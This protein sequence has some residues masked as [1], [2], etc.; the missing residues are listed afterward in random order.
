MARFPYALRGIAS[1]RLDLESETGQFAFH[2]V[3]LEGN[4]RHFLVR[5]LDLLVQVF[6]LH[7]T[8]LVHH[9]LVQNAHVR[10]ITRDFLDFNSLPRIQS[11]A[12]F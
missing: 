1:K 3:L 6:D 9:A 4:G 2:A 8:V 10:F 11:H 5:R 12:P 7:L